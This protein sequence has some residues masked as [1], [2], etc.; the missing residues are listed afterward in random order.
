MTGLYGRSWRTEHG[1]TLPAVWRAQLESM[2]PEEAALGWK[3]CR[4]SGDTRPCTLP[5][6][7]ARVSEALKA[8]VRPSVHRALPEPHSDVVPQAFKAGAKKASEKA[9]EVD[10]PR[11][12][13]VLGVPQ[14]HIRLFWP[15]RT[16]LRGQVHPGGPFG[17]T[18]L[19]KARGAAKQAGRSV[20]DAELE[21]MAMNGWTPDD[22]RE[23]Q[24]FTSMT[25]IGIEHHDGKTP[26]LDAWRASE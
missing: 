7:M 26:F 16:V 6:F 10:V 14:S 5:Q 22:E 2:T 12:A 15:R 24:R 8:K 21:L 13:G 19:R 4:A 11:L 9:A 1:D 3:A 18:D 25:S 17:M 20:Y 23:H